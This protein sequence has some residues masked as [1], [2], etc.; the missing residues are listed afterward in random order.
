MEKYSY[1]KPPV[2]G[3]M[4]YGR[5]VPR[6]TTDKQKNGEEFTRSG[7]LFFTK[8]AYYE[9]S[10]NPGNS[11]TTRIDLKI[12][13]WKDPLF[14]DFNQKYKAK[15]GDVI[16]E[17]KKLDYDESYLYFYLQEAKL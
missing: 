1:K 12:R 13:T 3:L 8:M 9:D 11:D 6:Y 16:Y 5:I 15:I 17:I 7:E 2:D 14:N 4:E 10:I